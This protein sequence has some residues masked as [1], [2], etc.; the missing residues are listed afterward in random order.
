VD[1]IGGGIVNL[2]YTDLCGVAQTAGGPTL[3]SSCPRNMVAYKITPN[4]AQ[5]NIL[6]SS[7]SAND[8]KSNSSSLIYAIKIL[9]H[10]GTA[11]KSFTFKT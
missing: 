7:V 5:N 11:I 4:P 8:L 6:V 9:D 1:V 2:H 3:Y 10:Y